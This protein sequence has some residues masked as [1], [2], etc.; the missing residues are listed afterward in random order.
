ME[1]AD[2]ISYDFLDLEEYINSPDI[3]NFPPDLPSHNPIDLK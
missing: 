1:E 2:Y 3:Y